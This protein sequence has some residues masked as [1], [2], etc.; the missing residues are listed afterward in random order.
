MTEH[1]IAARVTAT[2]HAPLGSPERG[3]LVVGILFAGIFVSSLWRV[4]KSPWAILGIVGGFVGLAA[5]LIVWLRDGRRFGQVGVPLALSQTG[6]VT[7]FTTEVE[8]SRTIEVL[9]AIREFVQN[10]QPLP[11]PHGK[12]EGD[13][14]NQKSLS[15]YTDTERGDVGKELRADAEGHSK[16]VITEIEKAQHALMPPVSGETGESGPV[17]RTVTPGQ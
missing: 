16:K 15:P 11:D 9:A 14:A 8:P 13:P 17:G 10:R 7:T 5:I 4:D 12:V 1:P 6:Q 2:V 3:L